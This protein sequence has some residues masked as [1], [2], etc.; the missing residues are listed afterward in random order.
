[1]AQTNPEKDRLRKGYV[2]KANKS[3]RKNRCKREG[4][5]YEKDSFVKGGKVYKGGRCVKGKGAL[6][7]QL[8]LLKGRQ[9]YK[10]YKL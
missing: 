5:V 1:M 6:K 10:R 2:N 8:V 7:G 3:I 4:H 9:V